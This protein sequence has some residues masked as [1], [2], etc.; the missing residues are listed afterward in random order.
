V[1]DSDLAA[2]IC[3]GCRPVE[4]WFIKKCNKG[5]FHVCRCPFCGSAFVWPRPDIS[6]IA[7]QYTHESY[8][9]LTYEEAIQ[10]D[11]RYYPDSSHDSRRILT[12]CDKLSA[13]RRLFDLGAGYGMYSK[14]ALDMG[15]EVSA[16]EPNPNARAVFLRLNGFEPDSVMFDSE[17]AAGN[18][19]AF[20]VVLLSQVLEHIVDPE[21]LVRNVRIV[22][23]EK[24]IAAVAVPHFGS[25]LSRIQGRRDMFISPPEHLNYFSKKGLAALFARNNLALEFIETVS[26]VPRGRIAEA[27]RLPVISGAA[28]RG[29]YAGL[30]LFEVFGMGMVINGYF[31]KILCV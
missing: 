28:W 22:L 3:C 10:S 14:T 24:G 5:D 13:G 27:V 23:G 11:R 20:D 19:E 29:V 8:S 9:N 7:G 6:V 12:V 2:C 26:K 25:A 31:R 30:K 16:C 1:R 17:Y 18:K 15:F 21:E 4:E